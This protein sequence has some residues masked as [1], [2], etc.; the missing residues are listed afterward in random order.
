MKL[1][2]AKSDVVVV[3]LL[4]KALSPVAYTRPIAS[5]H[6]IRIQCTDKI[7]LT[8]LRDI[9]RQLCVNNVLVHHGSLY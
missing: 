1:W 3:E 7:L 5:I 9:R 6:R 4:Q 2:Q 8:P